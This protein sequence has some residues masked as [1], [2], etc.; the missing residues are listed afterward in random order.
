MHVFVADPSM[1]L[2]FSH[3]LRFALRHIWYSFT[4]VLSFFRSVQFSLADVLSLGSALKARV[5]TGVIFIGAAEAEP[6][7]LT[8]LIVIVYSTPGS[9]SLLPIMNDRVLSL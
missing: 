8:A 4:V 9:I 2:T 3:L 5:L 6:L 1:V 7:S